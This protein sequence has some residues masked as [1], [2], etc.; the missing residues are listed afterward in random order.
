M[1]FEKK[2]IFN[3]NRR[4]RLRKERPMI[5]TV[6]LNPS[7]DFITVVKDLKKGKINRSYED[8]M[9]AGGHAITV[10]RFLNILQMPTTATGF[11]GGKTGAF[12]E[13]ELSRQGIAHHFIHI[14][15][16][17]RINLGIFSGGI[18]TRIN[19]TGPHVS[20]EEINDLMYY[21]SRIREG[22]VVIMAGSI[23][24]DMPPSVYSRIVEIAVVNGADFILHVD[25]ALV[26]PILQKGP[27]LVT[28]SL[29][30]LSEFYGQ[31]VLTKED[32]LKY[33][34]RYFN[35]GPKNV[36]VNMGL[37][38][39]ML[40]A[41]DGKIYEAGGP[42]KTIISTTYADMGLVAGFVGD[43]MRTGNPKEAFHLAQVI[44]HAACYVQTLPNMDLLRQAGEEV[45]ILPLN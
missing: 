42:G 26:K 15:E 21:L 9:N 24:K 23:P 36:L 45:E 2:M 1:G 41:E 4:T 31:E 13:D 39:S 19:G 18:E 28:P 33:G 16:N 6:T 14:K 5:Y 40:F 11:V 20:L 38:G 35:E 43:Y 3:L 25:Q 12:V 44:G 27:L 8:S 29:E 22:D 7:L 32:V 10:S 37:E 17:T 30:D 34:M